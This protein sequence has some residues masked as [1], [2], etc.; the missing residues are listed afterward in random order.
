MLF[1]SFLFMVL[2]YIFLLFF[3]KKI[4]LKFIRTHIILTLL[5]S[6]VVTGFFSKSYYGYRVLLPL[7]TIVLCAKYLGYLRYIFVLPCYL[8][9][10]SGYSKLYIFTS[11]LIL[12][13][14]LINSKLDSFNLTYKSGVKYVLTIPILILFSKDKLIEKFNTIWSEDNNLMGLDTYYLWDKVQD[15]Y[16]LDPLD[17]NSFFGLLVNPIPRLLWQDKPLA[18]GVDLSSRL[19][20][21][22]W[23]NIPTNYGPGIVLEALVNGGVVSIIF[24]SFITGGLLSVMDYVSKNLGIPRIYWFLFVVLYVRGD[25]L[26][27]SMNIILSLLIFIFFGVAAKNITR[28]R[29]SGQ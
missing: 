11:T 28:L 27:S 8:A 13:M 7:M 21:T 4:K 17:Y 5:F 12:G 2:T 24:F 22:H 14:F 26:N 3:N 25:F 16:R 20:G 23:T 29:L 1:Y 9:L 19:W 10:M 15:L 18:F 6:V